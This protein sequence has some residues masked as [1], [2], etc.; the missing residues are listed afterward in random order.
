MKKLMEK[1]NDLPK[2]TQDKLDKVIIPIIL[3]YYHIVIY[4][5]WAI[6]T[7]LFGISGAVLNPDYPVSGFFLGALCGITLGGYFIHQG[8]WL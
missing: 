5:L 3:V 2:E 6:F 1:Y 8:E 7:I 4:G